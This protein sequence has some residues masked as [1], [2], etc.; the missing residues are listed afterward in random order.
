M[1]ELALVSDGGRNPVSRVPLAWTLA[2]PRP[3]GLG[4]SAAVVSWEGSAVQHGPGGFWGQR[5]TQA[6]ARG[7]KRAAGTDRCI[8]TSLLV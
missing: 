4:A 2:A 7:A 3:P 8:F 6:L 5:Q 1:R